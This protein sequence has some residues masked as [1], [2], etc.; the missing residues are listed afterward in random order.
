MHM[1]QD[2]IAQAFQNYHEHVAKRMS[3]IPTGAILCVHDETQA[4]PKDDWKITFVIESHIIETVDSCDKKSRR[5]VYGPKPET[6]PH[7]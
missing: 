7:G 6:W 1:F 4:V 2:I 3:E 5:T